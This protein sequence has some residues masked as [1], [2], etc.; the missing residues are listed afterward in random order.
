MDHVLIFILLGIG[1]LS[2]VPVISLN[3]NGENKKYGCLKY[4][5]NL[6]FF[7]T[8]LILLERLSGNMTVVYITHI[9]GYPIKFLLVSF[10]VCTI[11]NYIEKPMP[12][13]IVFILGLITVVEVILAVTNI[14]NQFLIQIIPS[15]M[16]SFTDLYAAE[17][18]SLFIYHLIISYLVLVIGIGYLFYFLSKHK[19]VRQYKS[20]TQT[21]AISIVI[22]L[23]FNLSQL[24]FIQINADL[25]YISLVVVSYALY[26]I[27]YMKDM[28]F[29]IRTSGRS[30]ILS[31][32]REM[33]II[34]D[35]N[36]H[37]IEISN[38]LITKYNIDE[39]EYTGKIL[40]KLIKKLEE[41]ISFYK[42]YTAETEADSNKDHFHLRDKKFKLL[43]MNDY[44]YIILLYDETKVFGLLRDLNRLSNFDNMTGLNNRNY[45]EN[46]L[47]KLEEEIDLGIISLDL[48]GLKVNND[49]L[50]HERGDFLLKSLANKIK[51]VMSDYD[52][53]D[54]AR[55]GG[56][57][58]VIVLYH[59]D[60]KTLQKI[61]SN[62]LKAC[63]DPDL[64]KFVSVSIGTAF[65]RKDTNVFQLLQEADASM[66]EMKKTTSKAYSESIVEY[67]KKKDKFIR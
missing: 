42:E 10:M 67:V 65:S 55:I 1:F 8:I 14:D 37:V 59:T 41:Y 9:L 21:M 45:I 61:K 17:K 47:N 44:G 58:F 23:L 3:K 27:I 25:T 50:G 51:T 63:D 2:F 11:F 26:R 7:W 43:G 13:L 53:K 15:Q 38:L 16:N 19:G 35:S 24:L 57:E 39:A 64:E 48:N 12:K 52:N 46:K 28:V 54:I 18:G 34:T 29:N 66:Y 30:E 60:E 33:Y 4:L 5:I 56:D 40:D 6:G 31:N 36:Y 49:Y 62:I 22:V 32:M 20:I